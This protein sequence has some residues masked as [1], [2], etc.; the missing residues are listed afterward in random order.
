MGFWESLKC[1]LSYCYLYW[2]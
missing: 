1:C 2:T